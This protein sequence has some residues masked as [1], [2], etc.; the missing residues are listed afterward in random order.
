MQ[1]IFNISKRHLQKLALAKQKEVRTYINFGN[2]EAQAQKSLIPTQKPN[3]FDY[4]R[5]K[6]KRVRKFEFVCTISNGDCDARWSMS[7]C[8]LTYMYNLLGIFN[9]NNHDDNNNNKNKT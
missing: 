6:V 2:D 3:R 7:F 9:K 5:Y 1:R 8:S 4:K